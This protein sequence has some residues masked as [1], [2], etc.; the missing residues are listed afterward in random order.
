MVGVEKAVPRDRNAE[1]VECFSVEGEVAPVEV[2]L[3]V[4]VKTLLEIEEHAAG[5]GREGVAEV[6][7]RERLAERARKGRR[8]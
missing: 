6:E 8:E 2:G 5:R 4:G 7:P 1:A 3:Y